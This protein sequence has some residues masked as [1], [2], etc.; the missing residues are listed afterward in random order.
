MLID[1]SSLDPDRIEEIEKASIRLVSQAMFDFRETA[2]AIFKRQ[3]A[4]LTQDLAQD[5]A[6]DM[7]RAALDRIGVSRIDDRLVGKID[8]KRAR[9]VFHPEYAVKQALL[10][11]SKAEKGAE[12]VARVQLAQTSMEIRQIR[13]GTAMKVPGLLPTIF[14]T[15]LDKYI[16]T[17]IFV[18]YSYA[19]S[20]GQ[21]K[22]NKIIIAGIPN[23]MLQD[24]YN[25]SPGESIWNAGPDSPKRKEKFRTR[26]SFKK[27]KN[28]KSW[29]IQTIMIPSISF[30]WGD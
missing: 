14:D 8:Y 17:T 30:S 15:G 2:E 9:Y 10:V 20:E 1:P 11:D 3:T 21:N 13:G 19:L 6:E 16:T 24:Y 7:T 28:K 18:K 5:I 25:P 22:L 4:G 29:R 12:G 27:L 23:G 26:L